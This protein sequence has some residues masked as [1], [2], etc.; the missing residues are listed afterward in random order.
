MSSTC[1]ELEGSSSGRRFYKQVWCNLIICQ[2]YKHYC[3]W[4]SAFCYGPLKQYLQGSDAAAGINLFPSTRDLTEMDRVK[5]TDHPHPPYRCSHK[6][7][8]RE[9]FSCKRNLMRKMANWQEKF[10]NIVTKLHVTSFDLQSLHDLSPSS[11]IVFILTSYLRYIIILTHRSLKSSSLYRGAD[12]SLPRPGRK[13]ATAT[14]DFEFHISY[15]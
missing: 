11:M 3:R 15:L 12:K 6:N 13:K 9:S 2:R 7:S 1:I 5:E 4:K 10:V 8:R 14:D